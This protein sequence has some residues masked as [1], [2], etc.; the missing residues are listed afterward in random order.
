LEEN[1]KNVS[2]RKVYQ[3]A[4]EIAEDWLKKIKYTGLK[5]LAMY[6]QLMNALLEKKIQFEKKIKIGCLRTPLEFFKVYLNL[7]RT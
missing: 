5:N 6:F 7:L 2:T 1:K 4:H 3:N